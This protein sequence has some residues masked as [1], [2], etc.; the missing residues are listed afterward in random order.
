LGR[1]CEKPPETKFSATLNLLLFE[2]NFSL[3]R[4]WSEVLQPK[5]EDD[6]PL[7]QKALNRLDVNN[8]TNLAALQAA[9]RND[10]ALSNMV[11][12]FTTAKSMTHFYKA[13]NNDWLDGLA[14]N[15]VESLF[16]RYCP[17]DTIAGV[18]YEK[19]LKQFNLKKG[20]DPTALFDHFVEISTQYGINAPDEQ[21][22]IAIASYGIQHAVGCIGQSG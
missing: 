10:R 18:E 7:S 3:G 12:A 4:E 19:D 9:A 22:L 20:Q 8:K 5:P 13:A 14:A 15:L 11:V 2:P 17:K 21:K 1:N 16:K 6:L